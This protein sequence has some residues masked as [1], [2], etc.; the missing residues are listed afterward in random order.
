MSLGVMMAGGDWGSTRGREA[1]D[2]Y[3]TPADVTEA[4]VRRYHHILSHPVHKLWEPAAGNRV[5]S[6]VIERETGR[7]VFCSDLVVRAEGVVEQD[8]LALTP[9]TLPEAIKPGPV[10]P[11]VREEGGWRNADGSAIAIVTNPPFAH[12]EAF[13]RK[14]HALGASFIAM[15]VKSTFFHARKRYPLFREH[16]PGCVHP[17]LWRPDFLNLKGPTMEVSWMVWQP[18]VDMMTHYEPLARP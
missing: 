13:I 5:M 17:L 15:L 14:S 18:G 16:P 12:A 4:L 6:D 10:W 2:W 1:D 7:P 8:F 11:A 9:E 3:P